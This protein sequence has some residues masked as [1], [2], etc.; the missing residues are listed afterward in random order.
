MGKKETGRQR[1]RETRK[2]VDK[3]TGR[4]GNRETRKQGNR[5]TR[6]MELVYL[7]TCLPVYLFTPSLFFQAAGARFAR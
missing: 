3:E 2:Q 7:S 1:N 6:E 5:E 4:Q